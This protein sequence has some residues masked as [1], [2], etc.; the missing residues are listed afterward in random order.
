MKIGYVRV[1]AE[2][3]SQT[4]NAMKALKLAARGKYSPTRP[5]ARIARCRRYVP[6]LVQGPKRVEL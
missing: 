2:T 1:S 6:I 3:K 4:C 5:P